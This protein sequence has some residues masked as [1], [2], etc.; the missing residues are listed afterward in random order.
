MF[1]CIS[2]SQMENIEEQQDRPKGVSH[3]FPC[4]N[5]DPLQSEV[6]YEHRHSQDFLPL[7][8][9]LFCHLHIFNVQYYFKT[10]FSNSCC[11]QS[12]I[13][14]MHSKKNAFKEKKNL[15]S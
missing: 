15:E 9:T 7:K 12:Q 8:S 14:F 3:V 4:M 2:G 13:S 11:F 1:L 10:V 5:T 6:E